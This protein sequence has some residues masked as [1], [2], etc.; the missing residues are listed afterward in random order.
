MRI[1]LDIDGPI[2]DW[3]NPVY[4]YYKA[5]KDYDKS[6]TEF[7]VDY[8]PKLS[9]EEH[10][11]ILS[12][13]TLYTAMNI[14]DETLNAINLLSKL[15]TVYYVTARSESLRRITDLWFKR[16]NVPF[17]D[18]LIMSKDK[19]SYAKLLKLDYFV[20]DFAS[21]VIDLSGIT[22]AYLFAKPWNIEYQDILPTV[23]SL[24]EF[25]NAVKK[26]GSAK[27][28]TTGTSSILE[29]TDRIELES[30]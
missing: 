29:V 27:K 3:H 22:K 30:L 12:I 6:Y 17:R 19:V 4:D 7:W 2:Y 16:N 13:D 11:F 24:T 15:G 9:A 26:D 20:D 25:Y 14:T 18:N 21:Q 23:R 1:G 28:T 8:F 10:D 5:Y